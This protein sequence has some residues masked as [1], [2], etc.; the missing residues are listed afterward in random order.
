[1]MSNTYTFRNEK[2]F[3]FQKLNKYFLMPFLVPI[4]CFST[5]FFSETMKTDNGNRDLNN[6]TDDNVH[7]FC[8]LYQIIQSIC[9]IFGGLL[10]FIVK[11][12]TKSIK[13]SEIITKV[14]TLL[15]SD[16]D[17]ES[18]DSKIEQREII[19]SRV[20]KK[21]FDIQDDKKQMIKKILLITLMPILI[22]L[23]NLGIAYGVK[24]PQLEKRV[25]FLFFITLINVYAFKKQ[26]FKHQKLALIITVIGIIPVFLAFGIYLETQNYSIIYDITLFFGSFCYSLYLVFIKYLTLNKGM[27]VFLLL[28]YQGLLCFGYTVILYMIISSAIKGDLSYIADIFYCSDTNF[29]CITHFSVNISLYILLNTV[30]QTLI[31]LVV[32]YFSPELFAISDIFSPLFSWIATW[33]Q[34]GET[35]GVKI[36]LTVLGYLIIAFGAFIYNELIVCNFWGLNEN[37]WKA[38]SQK[39]YDEILEKD[40]RDSY[41][42]NAD[43]KIGRENNEHDED[44]VEMADKN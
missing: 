35:R 6:I 34:I 29:V 39:A 7:T 20:R 23:Y 16:S 14:S 15:S 28:L 10:Y 38:I 22:I 17:L 18:K 12:R 1:M 4:I 36:F 24:H 25:Y 5:K 31:F 44:N 41:N 3:S 32:Y 21:S 11:L 42:I 33:I 43:Y 30:L 26:I 40:I 13:E 19:M 37:T 27:S 8:F 9:L 2:L